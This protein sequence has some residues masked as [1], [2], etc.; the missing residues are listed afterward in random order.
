[1]ERLRRFA[2]IWFTTMSEI[3][4]SRAFRIATGAICC[5]RIDLQAL[6][7]KAGGLEAK[8]A[9]KTKNAPKHENR[10]PRQFDPTSG[11]I[12]TPDA[13]PIGLSRTNAARQHATRIACRR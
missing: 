1:M 4:S 12:A 11:P 10:L 2:P 3:R 6:A 9:E 13:T 8:G 7:T 5:I